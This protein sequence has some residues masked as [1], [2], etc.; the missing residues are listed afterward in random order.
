MRNKRCAE[1]NEDASKRAW[2]DM[3]AMRL[4]RC[5]DCG[6]LRNESAKSGRF[7]TALLL[8]ASPQR[9][10]SSLDVQNELKE[11]VYACT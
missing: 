3:H 8:L 4:S 7:G 6:W 9:R 2:M 10:G 5:F 1:G 11:R